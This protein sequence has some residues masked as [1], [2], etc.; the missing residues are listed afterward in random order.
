M[1]VQRRGIGDTSTTAGYWS[2]FFGGGGESVLT[3]GGSGEAPGTLCA[4]GLP[5]DVVDGVLQPCGGAA[6]PSWF[7]RNS[8]LVIG[9]GVGILALALL[10]GGRR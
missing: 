2:T 6:M 8:N 5:R 10:R 1:L 9:L 3:G 7:A 4:D